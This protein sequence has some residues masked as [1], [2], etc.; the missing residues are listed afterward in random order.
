MFKEGLAL[1]AIKG[2][3]S[4]YMCF[5]LVLVSTTEGSESQVTLLNLWLST[6]HHLA[7]PQAYGFFD[8]SCNNAVANACKNANLGL[9]LR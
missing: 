4:N 2:T 7:T 1:E 6:R 8:C 5:P 9:E 3:W